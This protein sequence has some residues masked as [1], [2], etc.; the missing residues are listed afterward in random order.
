MRLRRGHIRLH[1]LAPCHVSRAQPPAA[2][3]IALTSETRG[4]RPRRGDAPTRRATPRYTALVA[5]PPLGI[6]GP[7]F[8]GAVFYLNVIL[9]RDVSGAIINPG[10]AWGLWIVGIIEGNQER[11]GSSGIIGIIEGNQERRAQLTI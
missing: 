11:Q 1:H 2:A 9:F 8:V 5:D 6:W 4:V 7:V 10:V 3:P